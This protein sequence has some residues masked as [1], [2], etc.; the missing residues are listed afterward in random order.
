MQHIRLDRDV[1]VKRRLASLL[2]SDA[3][4][5]VDPFARLK[6]SYGKNLD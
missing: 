4:K 1:R 5:V 3:D 6:Q 2:I